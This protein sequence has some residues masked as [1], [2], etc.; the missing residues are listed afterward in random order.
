MY[1]SKE[2]KFDMIIPSEQRRYRLRIYIVIFTIILIMI[3]SYYKSRNYYLPESIGNDNTN[4]NKNDNGSNTSGHY[5]IM[6]LI[7]SQMEEYQYRKLL[8]SILFG[9]NDNLEPC[10]KYDTNI[11]YKFLIHPYN[12]SN[13]MYKSFVSE[14]VEYNDMVEFQHLLNSNVNYT[15][16]VVLNWTQSLKNT[17]I[18]F[19]LA[20]LLD[21]QSIM[22]LARLKKLISDISP[23]QLQN[24]VWSRFDD[25][26]ADD[27]FVILGSKAIHTILANKDLIYKS[28]NQNIIALAYLYAKSKH[29]PPSNSWNNLLFIN[30]NKRL[31]TH[32]ETLDQ[33]PDK[34]TIMVRNLSLKELIKVSINLLIPPI[35]VCHPNTPPHGEPSIAVVTSSYFYDNINNCS[36]SMLDVAYM[37]S[38]NKRIYAQKHGYAF[39]PRSL[40]FQQNTHNPNLKTWGRID[41]VKKVLPYYDW[42]LWIDNDAIIINQEVSIQELF[43]NKSSAN[44]DN[45]SRSKKDLKFNAGVFLIK[46]SEWSFEF[47]KKMQEMKG[48]HNEQES[49]W[50]LFNE[51]P[52]L[53]DHTLVLDHDDHTFTT[54]SDDWQNDDFI[55]HFASNDCP[56]Q[57]IL[58]YFKKE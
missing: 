31:I 52:S 58:D 19:D 49:M 44:N 33:I 47:L 27:M 3:C 55:V 2:T 4:S 56:A 20:V 29:Q 1:I 6:L 9:I 43:K 10:M 32:L 12:A 38:E 40:E 30:D 26:F 18:S 57:F 8:R 46:S 24:V 37:S 48:L 53:K 50:Q 41:A 17:G 23:I 7:T 21:N 22:N 45:I 42:V 11:Y 5:K 25:S 13:K 54:F 34:S 39:I 16:E 51:Y 28:D 36:P 14:S 15:Q 35:S